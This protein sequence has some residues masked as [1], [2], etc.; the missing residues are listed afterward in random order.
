[1]GQQRALSAG[2]GSPR[3][4]RNLR[5]TADGGLPTDAREDDDGQEEELSM[6]ISSSSRSSASAST[7]ASCSSS[8]ANDNSASASWTSCSSSSYVDDALAMGSSS[9]VVREDGTSP[10]PAMY[11]M[12]SGD[13]GNSGFCDDALAVRHRQLQ[14]HEAG[15][16]AAAAAA[17]TSSQ[18]AVSESARAVASSPPPTIVG[19]RAWNGLS[20]DKLWWCCALLNRGKS[21]GNP[22]SDE[23]EP[24]R[25]EVTAVPK[26]RGVRV[27]SPC[28]AKA[29][30]STLPASE[31]DNS[32]PEVTPEPPEGDESRRHFA[33][34]ER[35]ATP[36]FS[37]SLKSQQLAAHRLHSASHTSSWS[38]SS[39]SSDTASS[40]SSSLVFDGRVPDEAAGGDVQES[41]ISSAPAQMHPGQQL[42]RVQ[43][44]QASPRRVP[45]PPPS[46]V[47]QP[48]LATQFSS[49]AHVPMTQRHS[50]SNNQSG[51]S[52]PSMLTRR[53]VSAPCPQQTI[54][55]VASAALASVTRSNKPSLPLPLPPLPLVQEEPA[56]SPLRQQQLL[57]PP[58]RPRLSSQLTAGSS[59]NNLPPLRARLDS[60]LTNGS[61]HRRNNNSFEFSVT[62]LQ[63]IH[64]AATTD[65]FR[66]ESLNSWATLPLQTIEITRLQRECSDMRMDDSFYNSDDQCYNDNGDS[67]HRGWDSDGDDDD[68]TDDNYSGYGGAHQQRKSGDDD[69]DDDSHESPSPTSVM[70]IVQEQYKDINDKTIRKSNL[71]TASSATQQDWMLQWAAGADPTSTTSPIRSDLSPNF[72]RTASI[73]DVTNNSSADSISIGS[74]S[75]TRLLSRYL[76]SPA[77]DN[78]REMLREVHCECVFVAWM[79]ASFNDEL[80]LRASQHLK[81][82]ITNE[83]LYL[84]RIVKKTGSCGT[85]RTVLEAFRPTKKSGLS[86]AW[87]SDLNDLEVS[88]RT[89]IPLKWGRAVVLT[90]KAQQGKETLEAEET[91]SIVATFLPVPVRMSNCGCKPRLDARQLKKHD[92]ASPSSPS[93]VS[94]SLSS[95]LRQYS[96]YA[97]DG[98]QDAVMH[99]VFCLDANLPRPPVPVYDFHN[100]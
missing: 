75:S 95:S 85:S 96:Q 40:A 44:H 12:M 51:K 54:A 18:A 57:M 83:D 94:S 88:T 35:A 9:F 21:G 3:G 78:L 86:L 73:T 91:S 72:I 45:P 28:S 14:R 100:D 22:A 68:I 69:D 20:W 17:A 58:I 53:G 52:R 32:D 89:M 36:T 27:E 50:L 97:P 49:S 70:K 41:A 84:I 5:G 87:S 23:V 7:S 92:E 34:R 64:N 77:D 66:Q 61:L 15:I 25:G 2:S 24:A 42:N 79:A 99:L 38:S 74:C 11:M 30:G 33:V 82:T 56:S 59:G 43:P 81:A 65:Q 29:L 71:S 93:S 98:Q 31:D 63:Q 16:A 62:S 37:S 8:T 76:I 80:L 10:R 39:S 4:G 67:A 55:S 47:P 19:R 60:H 90:Q 1:M 48:S 46:N 26:L 13:A 6:T